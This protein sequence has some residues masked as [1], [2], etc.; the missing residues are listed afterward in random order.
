MEGKYKT[1]I[2]RSIAIEHYANIVIPLAVSSEVEESI[3]HLFRSSLIHDF[4]FMGESLPLSKKFAVIR[5]QL[6]SV[7]FSLYQVEIL[8]R[9]SR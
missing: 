6:V 9:L 1:Y 7:I 5:Q 8:F 4:Q 2:P 3:C